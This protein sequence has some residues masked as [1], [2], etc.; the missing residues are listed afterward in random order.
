MYRDGDYLVKEGYW[1]ILSTQS[2]RE[3]FM[4][5]GDFNPRPEDKDFFWHPPPRRPCN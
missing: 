1:Q 4:G 5:P 2:S 3:C